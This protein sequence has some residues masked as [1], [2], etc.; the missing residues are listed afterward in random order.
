MSTGAMRAVRVLSAPRSR[1][2]PTEWFDIATENF[3]MEWRL[4]VFLRVAGELGIPRDAPFRG[5]DVGCGPGI[6]RRQLERTSSWTVDGADIDPEA[7]TGREFER[8]ESLVYDVHDRR[9]EMGGAYDFVVLFDVLEHLADTR[10][11]PA[12]TLHHLRPGGWL[13]VN[14]PALN[15]LF[16]P[17]DRA[18]GH[19][20]RYDRR[21]MRDELAPHG[22]ELRDRRYWGLSLV[23][24]VLLRSLVTARA[25]SR[26]DVLR[27]GFQPPGEGVH[28]AL[29]TLMKLETTLVRRPFAGTSLMAAARKPKTA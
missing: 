24:L 6:F 7:F 8:G 9:P 10:G 29:R 28:A 21:M 12:S 18:A 14:V 23:P 20:R 5:L 13:F 16:G 27:R 17:Y 25:R 22:L 1:D 15:A 19:L 4:A 11:F 26:A 2:F 3:W